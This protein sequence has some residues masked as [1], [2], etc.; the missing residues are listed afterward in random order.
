MSLF[1][2]AVIQLYS[3]SKK[4][5]VF[6][7]VTDRLH[8]SSLH[9]TSQKELT[10]RQILRDRARLI[11]NIL[12]NINH[13]KIK[14]D[15]GSGLI[16]VSSVLSTRKQNEIRF[17]LKGDV[18]KASAFPLLPEKDPSKRF[19]PI[20]VYIENLKDVMLCLLSIFDFNQYELYP[21]T[22]FFKY[23]NCLI[24]VSVRELH[25]FNTYSPAFYL[26]SLLKLESAKKYVYTGNAPLNQKWNQG[27]FHGVTY[28]CSNPIQALELEE[29]RKQKFVILKNVEVRVGSNLSQL[30][31]ERA[32]KD[33][34]YKV[35][36]FSEGWWLR[37]PG[38]DFSLEDEELL[39]RHVQSK[40]SDRAA[41]EVQLFERLMRVCKANCL[42]LS[43]YP[44]PCEDRARAR[45]FVGPFDKFIDN[46]ICCYGSKVRGIS[47]FFEVECGV[48]MLSDSSIITDRSSCDLKTLFCSEDMLNNSINDSGFKYFVKLVKKDCEFEIESLSRL[49]DIIT[50]GISL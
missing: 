5:E 7:S 50:E 12:K 17:L 37:R 40:V 41:L 48:T 21:L 44:H 32:P 9:L 38:D 16:F 23:K 15:D 43:F 30:Y 4:S 22:S 34:K 1:L 42:T 19:T 25:I 35:G 33:F 11:F 18:S 31:L 46:D 26:L 3:S 13:Y 29:M 10:L 39:E 45:G 36:F 28:V 8:H 47:N 6:A 14:D 49:D 20:N 27:L 24:Y 2:K